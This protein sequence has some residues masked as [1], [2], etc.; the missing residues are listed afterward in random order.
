MVGRPEPPKPELAASSPLGPSS[1]MSLAARK[2]RLLQQIHTAKADIAQL[3]GILADAVAARARDAAILSGDGALPL[4]ALTADANRL[5]QIDRALGE[6]DGHPGPALAQIC[7]S[8]L[9]VSTRNF[10]R[11]TVQPR[12]EAPHLDTGSARRTIV[13]LSTGRPVEPVASPR[14]RESISTIENELY[15]L[16]AINDFKIEN[17]T[18]QPLA[19]DESA[20]LAREYVRA[21]RPPGD[22]AADGW[23][24]STLF[25]SAHGAR[26]QAQ[27]LLPPADPSAD[28]AGPPVPP[29]AGVH[30][31]DVLLSPGVAS[32]AEP[33]FRALTRLGGRSPD[34]LDL[35]RLV[36][37][38]FARVARL[39]AT[40]A[41]IFACLNRWVRDPGR[42]VDF[43]TAPPAS[44]AM[45]PH[46]QMVIL[47]AVGGRVGLQLTWEI[48]P[49]RASAEAQPTAAS[50]H[51]DIRALVER[52]LGPVA[53]APP[54]VLAADVRCRIYMTC[55]TGRSEAQTPDSTLVRRDAEALAQT[56]VRE[57]DR[58]VRVAGLTGA[59]TMITRHLSPRST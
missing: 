46:A 22:P 47:P 13:S 42:P 55:V 21:G 43:A 2:T 52:A 19:P 45:D 34:G 33:F 29:A 6:P 53:A 30:L 44:L 28:E 49:P 15:A 50:D 18:Y 39:A 59:L 24:A 20:H 5:R 32:E 26:M 3:E 12:G 35:A 14:D 57:F 37:R 9:D 25:V 56:L 48:G 1:S 38:T 58:L 7:S 51:A 36:L 54:W 41:H 16:E 8:L 31:Y 23:I 27:L 4:A 10:L 17:I 40:R 11:D